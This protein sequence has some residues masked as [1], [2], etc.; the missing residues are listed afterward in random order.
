MIKL[1]SNVTVTSPE[2]PAAILEDGAAT[3]IQAGTPAPPTVGSI[4]VPGEASMPSEIS[5]TMCPPSPQESFMVSV[6]VPVGVSPLKS[7]MLNE[8][9]PSENEEN[10]VTVVALGDV[11]VAEPS[12][13]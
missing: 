8:Y 6:Q 1:A 5:V 2:S 11:S 9:V 4:F 3:E 10:K 13:P 7:V 12:D